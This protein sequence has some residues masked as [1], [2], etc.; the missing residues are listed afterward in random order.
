MGLLPFLAAG[1]TQD[2]KGP[3]RTIIK[4]AVNYLLAKQKP[5]GSFEGTPTLSE[6]ASISTALSECYGMTGDKAVGK[7]AQAALDYIAAAQDPIGGGWGPGPRMAGLTSVTGGQI[8]AIRSG[9]LAKLKVAPAIFPQ[10]QKF[11]KSVS[12]SQQGNADGGLFG[13]G[14][15]K[16]TPRPTWTAVGLLCY[17][18]LGVPRTD[19]AMVEGTGYLMKNLPGGADQTADYWFWATQV[20][21]NQPGPDWET[22]G[23]KLRQVLLESQIKQGC[24]TGSWNPTGPLAA[25]DAMLRPA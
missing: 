18:Y 22:W 5:D 1:Q 19:P 2:H 7:A 17:Q 20:M 25:P 3:Y 12:F 10:A 6:H 8:M 13:S 15:D 9:Q 21:H 23:R 4:A 16:T 24:A 14:G 11:L